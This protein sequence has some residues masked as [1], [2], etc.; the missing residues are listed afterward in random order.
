MEVGPESLKLTR[1][2][3]YEDIEAYLTTFKRAVEAHGV[4]EKW[5]VILATN[6]TGIS[7]QQR[8]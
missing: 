6:P 5:P 4:K 7:I 3:K 8:W 1:L 2:M